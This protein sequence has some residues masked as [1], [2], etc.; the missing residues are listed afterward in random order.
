VDKKY[1][2][3]GVGEALIRRVIEEAKSLKAG[4]LYLFTPDQERYLSR[5]GWKNLF[6]EE[7]YGELETVMVLDITPPKPHRGKSSPA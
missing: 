5:F 2:R 7:Y 1:R 4:R 3:R 6:Q